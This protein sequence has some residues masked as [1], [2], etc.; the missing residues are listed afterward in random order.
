MSEPEP[1]PTDPADVPAVPLVASEVL[2][3]PLDA[4]FHAANIR[5]A[6]AGEPEG[7]WGAFE[8]AE[9]PQGHD[10]WEREAEGLAAGSP[11]SAEARAILEATAKAWEA[12]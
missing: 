5:D 2:T 9:T 1:T 11:L 10:F 4:R 6:L 7:L 8:W 12:A 3:E